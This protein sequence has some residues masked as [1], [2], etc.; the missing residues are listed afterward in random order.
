MHEVP[1]NGA[2]R[3]IGLVNLASLPA[4]HLRLPAHLVIPKEEEKTTLV[5]ELA[6]SFLPTV[7]ARGYATEAIT[8]VLQACR[9]DANARFWRPWSNV[10]MRVIVNGRNPASQRVMAKCGIERKGIFK[11][12]GEKIFIGGEWRTEDDLHIYGCYLRGGDE[13]AG[14]A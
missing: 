7:W 14:G 10:Y 2:P 13:E 4:S 6:Y 12:E 11:W 3:F 5:V 8:A 9:G 1:Q